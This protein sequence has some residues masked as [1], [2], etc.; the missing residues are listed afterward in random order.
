MD[1]LPFAGQEV[2]CQGLA[3]GTNWQ[4]EWCWEWPVHFLVITKAIV[5]DG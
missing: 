4:S 5:D 3:G 1:N 2:E